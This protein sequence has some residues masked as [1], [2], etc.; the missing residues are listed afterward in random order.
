[1]SSLPAAIQSARSCSG[2]VSLS[3]DQLDAIDVIAATALECSV[4]RPLGNLSEGFLKVSCIEAL[5]FKGYSLLES[6][7]RANL[8]RLIWLH[9]G[10]IRGGLVPRDTIAADPTSMKLWN[11]ADLRVYSPCT[12]VVELQCRSQ[13]GSQ[14]AV[15]SANIADDLRRVDRGTAHL[16]VLAAD[17]VVYDALRGIK[18]DRRGRKAAYSFED[19]FPE[20]TPL[21]SGRHVSQSASVRAGRQVFAI[22]AESQFGTDRVVLCAWQAP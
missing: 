13:F 7:N 20:P 14:A 19:D 10:E 9:D 16:F 4:G 15:F 1:M 8:G 6:S 11:S 5:L 3:P 12:L 17:R 21:E 22:A 2:S 18:Q